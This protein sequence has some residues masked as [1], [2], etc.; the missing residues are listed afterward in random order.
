MPLICECGVCAKTVSERDGLKCDKCHYPI[1]TTCSGLS[2]SDINVAKERRLVFHCNTCFNK[3]SEIEELKKLICDLQQQI[4]L[5]QTQPS[6]SSPST[7]AILNEVQDRF[8][9]AN[10]LLVFG[11]EEQN[12]NL[13]Q[14]ER[15]QA[16]KDCASRII[17]KLDNT[18]NTLNIEVF[19]VGK[20]S[21]NKKRPV[22]ICLSTRRDVFQLLKKNRD[23]GAEFKLS[24]DQTLLQR[25]YFKDLR[26]ELKRRTDAGETNLTIKYKNNQPIITSSIPNQEQKN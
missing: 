12:S 1:H 15:K 23:S 11:L 4:A 26:D 16:D 5:L 9:R 20:F 10:N 21:A 18:V 2:R 3:K 13:N 24:T 22:K 14:A 25:N 19:R 6:V 8:S 17:E 7:E